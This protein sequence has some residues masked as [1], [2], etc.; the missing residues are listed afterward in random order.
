[1]VAEYSFG[2]DN[3]ISTCGTEVGCQSGRIVTNSQ[4]IIGIRKDEDCV[5]SNNGAVAVKYI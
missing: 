2:T 4:D 1:V 3:K 5:V